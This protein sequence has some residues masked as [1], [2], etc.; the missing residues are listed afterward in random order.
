MRL[1]THRMLLVGIY[2]CAAFWGAVQVLSSNTLV[3]LLGSVL[4]ALLVTG[5]CVVDARKLGKPML[6]V[7]QMIMF[8][9][10]PIAVPIYLIW[11]RGFRG[12]GYTLLHAA[13]LYA[14]M[15]AAVVLTLYAFYGSAAF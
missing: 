11:T 2:A 14:V 5:W 1:D 15:A 9:T 4:F 8:F 12:L 3:I 10:W 6:P 7:V 13:G